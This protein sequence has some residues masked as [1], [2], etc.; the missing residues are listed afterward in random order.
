M[1]K[2]L[3]KLVPPDRQ[4]KIKDTLN[5]DTFSWYYYETILSDKEINTPGNENITLTPAYVHTLFLLPKGINSDAYY[6]L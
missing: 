4:K 2:I 6:F 5:S 1:I 3:T